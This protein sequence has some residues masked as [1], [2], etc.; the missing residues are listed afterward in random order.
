MKIK[1]IIAVLLLLVAGSFLYVKHE[2]NSTK[3]IKVGIMMPLTGQFG[4]VGEGIANSIELAKEEYVKAH[5]NMNIT[6]VTEDDA[7]DTKKGISAY[8]KL[9]ELDHVQAIIMVSTPVLDALHE[10]MQKDGI[11]IISIGLQNNGI[12]KDNIFQ[13]SASPDLPIY[14]LAKHVNEN[15]PYKRIAIVYSNIPGTIGFYNSFVSKFTGT[16]YDYQIKDQGDIRTVAATIVSKKYDAIVFLNTPIDGAL[17]VKDILTFTKTPPHFVFDIQ[18]QTGWSEYKKVLGDTNLLNGSITLALKQGD[19][20]GE[21]ASKYKTKFSSD[22]LPFSEYGYDSFYI[23]MNA[24]AIN[25]K[26]W[27]NNIQKTKVDGPSGKISFDENGVR[28]QDTVIKQVKGGEIV[29]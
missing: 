8:K 28:I 7:F 9:I 21:F 5:P 19:S 10:Q 20:Y 11:P 6:F 13:T 26:D 12:A 1:I 18:L 27:I 17:I 23:L 14:D 29:E 15:T 25:N 4:A 24:Y 2:N 16:H 3:S 22:P